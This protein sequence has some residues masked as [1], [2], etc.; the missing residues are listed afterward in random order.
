MKKIVNKLT[1]VNGLKSTP[2]GNKVS[3]LAVRITN[4]NI[5]KTISISDGTTQFTIPFEP[6]EEY[7]K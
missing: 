6:I 4:D 2:V 5:G 7:L 1:K 3:E